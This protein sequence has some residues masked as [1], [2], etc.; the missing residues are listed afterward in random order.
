MANKDLELALRIKADLEQG[1]RALQQ[2]GTSVSDVGDQAADASAKLNAVGESA[3]QQ[4]ARI[5]TM[6]A[7]SLEQQAALNGIETSTQRVTQAAAA[8]TEQW[9]QTAAAQTAVMT[10]HQKTASAQDQQA[11]ANQ[12]VT[13]AA[14]KATTE[15][16]DEG[17]ALARLLGQI[18]PVVGALDRLDDMERQLRAARASGRLDVDT[19]DT[20]NAKLTEQRTRLTATTSATRTAALTAGQYQQAMRQLPMQLTDVT[21]SLASGMPVWMVAIQ[22]GGQIKDSFGGIG[23]AARA[24]VSAINPLTL[25]IGAVAAAGIAAA[26]AY[27][28][29]SDEVTAYAKAITLT[30]NSAGTSTDQLANMA[31][32]I[33]GISGTQHQAAAALAEI[34]STGKFTA[35]QI[36]EIGTAAVLME[37]TTG[38]AI[39]A[40]VAEFARLADDP[41]KAAAALNEQYHFL[42]ATVYEQIRALKDQGDEAGAA[43]L[44]IDA[45]AAAMKDRAAEIHNNL[46]L[47]EG[48]WE[49]I[50]NV[51]AEAWDAMLGIGREATLDEK[52]KGLQQRLAQ[53]QTGVAVGGGIKSSETTRQ[54]NE[55]RQQ[56]AELEAKRTRDGADAAAAGKNKKI[57][58]DS[59]AAQAA[60]AAIREQSL[61]KAEQ[62]EKEIAEY[63][64]NVE[65]IR[66]ANPNSP[67][68]SDA[69][70]KKDIANI[71]AKYAERKTKTPKDP[72][73]STF[74]T[75][76]RQI[77]ENIATLNAATESETK[78]TE[79]QRFREK[80]LASM[81]D[82]TTK[83][84]E[85]QKASIRTRLDDLAVADQAN[86]KRTDAK[87]LV[88][89]QAQLQASQGNSAAAVGLQVEQQY[90]ELLARLKARGDE[91]GTDLVNSLINVDKA[92][93]ALGDLQSSVD[94]VFAEQSRRENSIQAQQQAGL[95]SEIGARQ[96]I[97]DLHAATAAEI[98]KLLPE[99]ERLAAATGDPA[100]IERVKNLKAQLADTKLVASEL[101]NALRSGFE[102][103]LAG[104]LEGLARGTMD[105]QEA[106]T[107]F[108]QSIAGSLAQLAAQRLAM[109]AADAVIGLFDGGSQSA[110]MTKGA[111]AVTASAAA[112]GAAG[113]TL[114][115]GAAAIEKAAMSLAI[116]NGIGSI[117]GA[118]VKAATG[119]HVT[120][121]G[122]GTSDSIRAWLSNDEFV[123]RAA[124]ATQ[125]GMLPMLHDINARGWDAI[126][127]WAGAVRHSTG[128]LA[129]V[130][131]PSMPSPTM[132]GRSRIADNAASMSTT[133][134][135]AV[136]L[137]V[138]DDPVRIAE[139]AFNSRAGQD[140]FFLMLSRD[141]GK[142]RSIL[143]VNGG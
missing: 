44:A 84:T 28:Q 101:T 126:Y 133:V 48:A 52:I 61:T 100:A 30:G 45:F 62:K 124:V 114:L 64:R 111:V 116:A 95:I 74:A 13:T 82:G 110:D 17:A 137:H 3:D 140:S 16:V 19:F 57:N 134:K 127:D 9:Q 115:T 60:I 53:L 83:L 12:R 72:Q 27:K 42:T 18:D 125:P 37:N 7:A 6:V 142:V 79:A 106:A 24:V 33:D 97:V 81:A 143:N 136:N 86:Q 117:G 25:A 120:G 139:A 20:Y 85:A 36:R 68:I 141:P 55:L 63:R 43:Q 71:E 58:D 26:L 78:L 90:G 1:R 8:G 132:G 88:G 14:A 4:A 31:Q 10:A 56:I 23:P 99:M 73:D 46:G 135:N 50:K 59:I 87:A 122:T 102:D 67:L 128:G 34:T 21:T 41:V 35:E 94:S 77:T 11:T 22:Q 109:M 138:Y 89:I 93:A 113:G 91:A 130:P 119:G 123:T 49:G 54:E 76:N 129:G 98:E 29:G 121:P 70:Q 51:A 32:E 75:L 107:S 66:T 15:I 92:K 40:T 69:Q 65:K 39:S 104:A 131:A 118:G 108:V 47:I 38:K 2:L 112:L 96:Q 5:R 103:G 80:V 105:L